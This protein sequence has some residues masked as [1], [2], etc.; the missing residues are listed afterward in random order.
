MLYSILIYGCEAALE[1][2]A[3]EPAAS[4]L[5][6]GVTLGPTLHLLPTSTAVTLRFGREPMVLDGPFTATNEQLLGICILDCPTLE[7]AI[8]AAGR[9][10]L[11]S[12]A[13][14]IR[15][16]AWLRLNHESRQWRA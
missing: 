16:I 6:P 12:G 8:D 11:E 14:E 7:S 10:T 13:L 1:A 2:W 5:R 4:A 15:P 9:F 3:R